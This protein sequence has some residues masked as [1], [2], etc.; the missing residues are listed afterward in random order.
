[1]MVQI[2]LLYAAQPHWGQKIA[3]SGLMYIIIRLSHGVWLAMSFLDLSVNSW[4]GPGG[5]I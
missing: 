1:M 3:F 5:Q 4:L 2:H